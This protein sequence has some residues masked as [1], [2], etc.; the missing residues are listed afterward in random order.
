MVDR[1]GLDV[2]RHARE[3]SL[4]E[5]VEGDFHRSFA[6]S[7]AIEQV[8]QSDAGPNG[9]LPTAPLFHCA[10]EPAAKTTRSEFPEH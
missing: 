1:Q 6:D 4:V 9:A 10:R 8:L 7:G 3:R 5:S 2:I